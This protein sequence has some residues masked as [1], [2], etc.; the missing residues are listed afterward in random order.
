MMPSAIGVGMACGEMAF[1]RTPS[2]ASCLATARTMPTMAAFDMEYTGD[3]TP[4]STAAEL[5]VQRMQP[6]R[7]G[8]MTRAACLTHANIDR[9]LTAMTRSYSSRSSAASEAGAGAPMT[10]AL[11]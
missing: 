2:R 10:P 7:R 6:A 1:T 11:L 5:A 8:A 4:P 3:A 9:A